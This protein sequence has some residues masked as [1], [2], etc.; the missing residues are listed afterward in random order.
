MFG[1]V[2]SAV[3]LEPSPVPDK[4]GFVGIWAVRCSTQ[5]WQPGCQSARVRNRRYSELVADG[6]IREVQEKPDTRRK[7]IVHGSLLTRFSFHR[8]GTRKNVATIATAN[9]QYMLSISHPGADPI[10]M[11]D[12][13]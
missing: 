13:N 12:R 3:W 10:K 6:L 9:T 1:L 4:S 8:G 2:L 7:L 11:K 5:C